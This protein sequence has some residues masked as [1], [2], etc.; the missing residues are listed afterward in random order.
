MSKK[1]KFDPFFLPPEI[2]GKMSQNVFA[3]KSA[4]ELFFEF[5]SMKS[6]VVGRGVKK[7]FTEISSGK[8]FQIIFNEIS[9]ENFS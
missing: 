8:F 5:F 3:M 6:A 4:V 9:S 7:F 2:C 1:I